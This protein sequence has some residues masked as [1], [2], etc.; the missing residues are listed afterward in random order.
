MHC[1]YL[2]WHNA[3][4]GS[5]HAAHVN[6][7]SSAQGLEDQNLRKG[8]VM[9]Q[10][11][12]SVRDYPRVKGMV[13]NVFFWDHNHP[14][15]GRDE[16]ASKQNSTEAAMAARLALYLTQQ[17]Y[18]AGDI[19]IVTPY[20]GQL[21]LLRAEVRKYMQFVVSDRDAEEL[22]AAQVTHL[23][24]AI[25]LSLRMH[26][27]LLNLLFGLWSRHLTVQFL[28]QKLVCLESAKE[29]GWCCVICF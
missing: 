23:G 16:N 11:H 27:I 6:L 26:T 25:S 5:C 29:Y 13:H 8:S 3:E 22:A 12:A 1:T 2:S 10:D 14:E 4:G 17:G 19:T 20:V 15:G 7:L 24:P 28:H 9:M 21:L 18:K